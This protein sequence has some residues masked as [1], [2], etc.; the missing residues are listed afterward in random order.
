[1]TQEEF[2]S[3]EDTSLVTVQHGDQCLLAY[4]DQMRFFWDLWVFGPLEAG[5]P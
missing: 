2:D 4:L 1:L 3:I 5:N